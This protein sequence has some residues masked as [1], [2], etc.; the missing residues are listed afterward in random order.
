MARL[1][2]QE[3]KVIQPHEELV[4]VINLGT[5][6]EAKEVRV[7]PALQDEVKTKLIELLKEYKDVFAWSY[8][9]MPGLDTDIVVHHLPLKEECPPVKKKR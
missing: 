4:E 3:E 6:E 5:D 8:Q 1:L 9:D 7:G 2:K